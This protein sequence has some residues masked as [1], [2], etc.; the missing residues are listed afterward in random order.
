MISLEE[1]VAGSAPVSDFKSKRTW[2]ASTARTLSQSRSSVPTKRSLIA[3][4]ISW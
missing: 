4:R 1:S 2:G 3:S